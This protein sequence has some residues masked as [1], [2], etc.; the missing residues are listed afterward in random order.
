[1][2]TLVVVGFDSIDGAKSALGECRELEKEYLL[3]LEDAVVV[4]RTQDGK[5]HLDQSINLEKVGASWGL[6]SGGF[7]GALVGLLFLNPLAGF[8]V[9]SLAGAGIGALDGKFS[10]YGIDDGFIKQLGDTLTPNTSALF[11][12]IRKAEPEKVIAHLS[13]L[14][15]HAK[16]LQTS[17][18]PEAEDK[19]RKA[20]GQAAQA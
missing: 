3:D 18:S 13:E 16:I 7:W 20:L 6:L 17:L 15:G 1:M 5:V 10:D 8:I 11:I 19:L 2:S 14:K 9:G 4:R 12:L